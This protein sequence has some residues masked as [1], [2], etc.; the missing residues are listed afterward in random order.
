MSRADRIIQKY[1]YW[2]AAI[3]FVPVIGE[4]LL[5]MLGIMRVSWWKVALVMAVGKL[6]RYT[7]ITISYTGFMQLI[8]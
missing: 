7:F 1:G 2:A 4:T 6:V 8:D 3:S 5:V